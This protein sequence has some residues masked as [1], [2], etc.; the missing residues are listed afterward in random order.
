MM[1]KLGISALRQGANG[2]DPNAPNAA[3]YDESKANPYPALPDPLMLANGKPV[4]S[5]KDWWKKRRPEL[6]EL[7]DREIYGRTPKNLPAVTWS[8]Q[9]EPAKTWSAESRVCS[10]SSSGHV[11]NSAYP[12]VN[13]DI[14]AELT[15]PSGCEGRAGHRR[16][17]P[18]RIPA[19]AFRRNAIADLAGAGDRA[20]LGVRHP[21]A[22]STSRPTTAPG[23]TKGIIGLV[24]KGQPR[25]PDDW[26]A[27]SAWAWGASR[28]ARLPRN[29]SGSGCETRRDRR[30]V[31]LRQ[32][33]AGDH[34][35]RAAFRHRLH[36][37]FGRGR[38]GA[39][40]AQLG[41]EAR[42]RRGQRRIP[43]DG[44]QLH[45]VRRRSARP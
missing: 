16:V 6:V 32:G 20:R 23:L 34:G 42:E 2:R 45:Q 28:A 19:A 36:R 10:A 41:R 8:G 21:V 31:A 17:L 11:D 24:N 14:E 40:A 22:T 30:R 43:L 9:G 25:K 18:V 4:K 5:A 37:L 15:T 38:C 26:G 29:Q 39:G 27:L 12:L 13:V 1:E 3:N 7:F 33:G 44:R 35:L